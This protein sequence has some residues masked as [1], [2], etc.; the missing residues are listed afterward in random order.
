MLKQISIFTM[1]A[2]LLLAAGQSAFANESPV[3]KRIKERGTI[4][5]GHRESSV[6]FSYIGTEGKPQGYSIDLCMKVIDAIKAE[7]GVS[8]LKAILVPETSQTR[9]ALLANV[10]RRC[11]GPHG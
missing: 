2:L 4:N 9:I 7:T 5:M 8:D 10:Y 6:P 3:L 11:L 1:G